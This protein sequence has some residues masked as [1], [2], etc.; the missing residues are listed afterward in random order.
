MI[1]HYTRHN[2]IGFT[3]GRSNP[4]ED[5]YPNH[6]PKSTAGHSLGIGGRTLKTALSV[7]ICLMAAA[8]VGYRM[9][10]YAC[11][12]AVLSLRATPD[13]SIDYGKQRTAGTVIGGAAAL[14]FLLVLKWF[15]ALDQPLIRAALI[16]CTLILGL[17]ICN[18]L[19][20]KEAG[21]SSC[22][23]VILSIVLASQTHNPY[24]FALMRTIETIAGIVVAVLVNRI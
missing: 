14:L 9:P 3:T 11:V 16:P 18:R 24:W 8:L 20:Q 13:Q 10:F 1:H 19:K 6:D 21:C 15:P 17:L 7:G 23:V 5:L 22:C 4:L 12:A 2:R